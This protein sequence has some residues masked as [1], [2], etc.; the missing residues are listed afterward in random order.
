MAK[1][2]DNLF[3]VFEAFKHISNEFKTNRKGEKR[4]NFHDFFVFNNNALSNFIYLLTSNALFIVLI[5]GFIGTVFLGLKE[6]VDNAY[7]EEHEI[8]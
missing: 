5:I 4:M 7:E 1:G 6:L 3:L 8:I 2:I